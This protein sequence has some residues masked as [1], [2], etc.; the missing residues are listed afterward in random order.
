LYGPAEVAAFQIVE[1]EVG[2]PGRGKATGIKIGYTGVVADLI[3]V[4]HSLVGGIGQVLDQIGTGINKIKAVFCYP[5][6]HPD[7]IGRISLFYQVIRD[8]EGNGM[9]L[10]IVHIGDPGRE[11]HIAGDKGN[12]CRQY[13]AY[14]I[15]GS[16]IVP[17]VFKGQDIIQ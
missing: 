11:D 17:K 2:C 12:I 4:D 10:G 8:G 9:R 13:V 6:P 16:I 1:Q 14:R 5:D 7:G 15:V 3:I